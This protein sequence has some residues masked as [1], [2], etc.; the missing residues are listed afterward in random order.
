MAKQPWDGETPPAPA[1][2]VEA[3]AAA[4]TAE[5]EAAKAAVTT[6]DLTAETAS[7]NNPAA[8]KSGAGTDAP[9]KPVKVKGDAGTVVV[10]GPQV[11][12]QLANLVSRGVSMKDAKKQLGIK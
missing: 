8:E 10:G 11:N 1:A 7:D 9:T 12:L 3:A 5:A 2:D 6:S 4:K